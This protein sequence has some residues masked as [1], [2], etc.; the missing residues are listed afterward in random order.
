MFTPLSNDGT[1]NGTNPVTMVSSPALNVGR[2]VKSIVIRNADT[3]QTTVTIRYVDGANNRDI[4]VVTL[5]I[6]DSLQFNQSDIQVLDT[7]TKSISVL[8]S[9]PKTT[10][11]CPWVAAYADES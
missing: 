4:Y 5:D 2:M 8:L 9:A 11:D 6:G 7:T 10:N 3:V 1:T